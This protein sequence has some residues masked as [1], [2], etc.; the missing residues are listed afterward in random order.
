MAKRIYEPNAVWV[1][2]YGGLDFE[3][4][5]AEPIVI[6]TTTRY[7]AINMLQKVAATLDRAYPRMSWFLDLIDKKGKAK[8]RKESVENPRVFV[9]LERTNFCDAVVLLPGVDYPMEEYKNKNRGR[10]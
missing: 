4:R 1:L 10:I 6:T 9:T 7:D 5:D 3:D 8:F 2:R